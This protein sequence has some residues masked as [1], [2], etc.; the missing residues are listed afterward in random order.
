MVYIKCIAAENQLT[1]TIAGLV[2]GDP[3]LH[4]LGIKIKDQAQKIIDSDPDSRPAVR[5]ACFLVQSATYKSLET[6]PLL[7]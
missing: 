7:S 3:D 4:D 1:S 6:V 5:A 2:A